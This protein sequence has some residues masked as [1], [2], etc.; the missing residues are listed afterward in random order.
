MAGTTVGREAWMPECE[1][2]RQHSR[3]FILSQSVS[4]P[5]IH[6]A[7]KTSPDDRFITACHHETAHQ[8]RRVSR[9]RFPAER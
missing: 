5:E 8:R 7:G 2:S 9:E 4:P 3:T 1:A 6:D